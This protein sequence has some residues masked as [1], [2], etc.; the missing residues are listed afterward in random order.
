[1]DNIY[2][3]T[4]FCVW[5]IHSTKH[6]VFFQDLE[7]IYNRRTP[8]RAALLRVILRRNMTQQNGFLY[9]KYCIVLTFLQ[10]YIKWVMPYFQTPRFPIAINGEAYCSIKRKSGLRQH[11]HLSPLLFVIF[12]EYFS[13][14][15]K[16]I[17]KQKEFEFYTK[18]KSLK[19]NHLYYADDMLIFSKR[20][21]NSVLLMLRGSRVDYKCKKYKYFLSKD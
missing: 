2:E 6:P 4:C 11:D 17:A 20:E 16:Q 9:K 8:I 10:K 14:I 21:I 7:R 15:K 3:P 13:R 5:Y 1:M 12:L 19:L 18:C